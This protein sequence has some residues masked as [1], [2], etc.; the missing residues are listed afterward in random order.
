[1]N[2]KFK[3][4]HRL[5]DKNH[6]L[7]LKIVMGPIAFNGH[8]TRTVAL[9]QR[10]NLGLRTFSVYVQTSTYCYAP[11]LTPSYHNGF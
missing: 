5:K 7:G 8:L 6:R 2:L 4:N 1:M 9:S 10:I 11:F 3:D